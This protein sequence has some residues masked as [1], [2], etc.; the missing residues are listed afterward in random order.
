MSVRRFSLRQFPGSGLVPDLCI[1]G[2]IG[3]TPKM[4]SVECAFQGCCGDL[5]IPAP[6]APM[7]KHGL[8]NETCFELFIAEQGSRSY[9]EFNLSP[10]GHW[11][12][13]RFASYRRDG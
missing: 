13:Y 1:S 10:A 4:L 9:R 6:A 2:S 12:V 8:W 3:R 5:E 11:N 7:R